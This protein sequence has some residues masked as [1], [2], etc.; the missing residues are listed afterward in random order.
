MAKNVHPPNLLL[1]PMKTWELIHTVLE[2]T[3]RAFANTPAAYAKKQKRKILFHVLL[4][5]PFAKQWIKTIQQKENAWITANRPRLYFKPFRVYLSSRWDKQQ[6][7]NALLN[8]YTYIKQHPGLQQIICTNRP[9]EI[10]QFATKDAETRGHITLGYDERYRKEGEIVIS[11]RSAHYAEPVCEAA[12][13][14]DKAQGKWIVRIG[15]IQGSKN[16]ENENSIKTLQKSLYGLRPKSLMIY[17]MQEI[18]KQLGCTALY[19]AGNKIQAHNKKH[20]IH[21]PYLHKLKCDYDALWQESGGELQKDGWY[22]LPQNWQRKPMESIKSQ[23]R[24]Q[25]RKR[26]ELLDIIARQIR[27]NLHD[28]IAP[29]PET[30]QS[31]RTTKIP[32]PHAQVSAHLNNC[33]N[34]CEDKKAPS[35]AR[36]TETARVAGKGQE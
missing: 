28:K 19:G 9:V 16:T 36:R 6:R 14:I 26:Y 22:Q 7:Q 35:P 17:I 15:C 5:I 32:S 27:I 29:S 33:K 31:S 2:L 1:P 23:K 11:L 12:F 30:A 3:E 8:C 18:G 10:A 4:D 24:A 20:F 25:Y 13:T 34:S 21:I